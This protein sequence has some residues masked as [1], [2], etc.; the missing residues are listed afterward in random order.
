M[1]DMV[2][3]VLLRREQRTPQPLNI[4]HQAVTDPQPPVNLGTYLRPG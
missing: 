4:S 2:Q 3:P 1:D